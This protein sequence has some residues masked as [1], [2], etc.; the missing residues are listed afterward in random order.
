MKVMHA[1]RKGVALDSKSSAE[2]VEKIEYTV[3]QCA[4]DL[5]EVKEWLEGLV[6]RSLHQQSDSG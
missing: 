2:R 1:L 6:P 4:R 5:R 3:D